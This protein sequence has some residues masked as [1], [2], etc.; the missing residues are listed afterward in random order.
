MAPLC[1]DVYWL[2]RVLSALGGGKAEGMLWAAS[3]RR[4]CPSAEEQGT[5][6]VLGLETGTVV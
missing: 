3:A 2:G 5:G 1:A 6:T 4:R